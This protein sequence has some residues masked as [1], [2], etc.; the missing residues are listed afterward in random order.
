[1]VRKMS[2]HTITVGRQSESWVS[3]DTHWVEDCPR[4]VGEERIEDMETW[5]MATATEAVCRDLSRQLIELFRQSPYD[6]YV[7]DGR[8]K[9]TLKTLHMHHRVTVELVLIVGGHD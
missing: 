5:A 6:H 1:M 4:Y 8:F 9:V 2:E 7:K 3:G